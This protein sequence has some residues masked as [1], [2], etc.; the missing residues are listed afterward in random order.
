MSFM[1]FPVIAEC[2]M[3]MAG[4]LI[5]IVGASAATSIQDVGPGLFPGYSLLPRQ[6][7]ALHE[8]TIERVRQNLV[9]TLVGLGFDAQHRYVANS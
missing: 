6:C 8:L 7:T 3:L 1:T 2:I 5:S 4:I 9:G